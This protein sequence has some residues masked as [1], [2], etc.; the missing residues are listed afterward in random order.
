MAT[1]RAAPVADPAP[2]P[3]RN[4][5]AGLQLADEVVEFSYTHALAWPPES[6]SP[7]AELQAKHLLTRP[8][9]QSLTQ[10]LTTLRGQVAAER[11]MTDPRPDQ[12]PLHAGFIDLPTKLLDAHRRKGE[13][14]DLGRV[15]STGLRLREE[16]DRVVILG[17][18]AASLAPRALFEAL[19]ASHHNELPASARINRPRFYFE[20]DGLDSDALQELLA[21]LENN[22]VDP[23][24]RAERWGAVTIGRDADALETAVAFR[25]FRAEAARYYGSNSP[26]LKRVL[27]PVAPASGTM[28][29]LFKA[30]GYA[31]EDIV[32]LP[33]NLGRFA[34][35]SPAALLPAAVMGIDVRALLLGA[36]AMTRRF[37]EE[38][39]ERNPVLQL[40]AVNFLM[41]EELGK[42][43]R[44]LAVW[45]RKLE[46]LGRWYE[47]LLAGS[48]GKQGRG[49]TPLTAVMPRDLYNRGQLHQ[50]GPRDKVI[51]NVVVRAAKTQPLAIGM[52]DRNEDGLN[53]IAR[54]THAD[55]QAA[56]LQAANQALRDVARPTAD[57]TLP[58]LSEHVL[59]QVMQML[60][61]ATVVEGRLMGLNP[62][63]EP[64]LRPYKAHLKN[65]LGLA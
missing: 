38:P 46:A 55:L 44:V 41:T 49:P 37:L 25:L 40:A 15:I 20:G 3:T 56:S 22:C 35:L 50:D 13:A 12:Q 42:H 34:A 31:D 39:F 43:V 30:D 14:S 28:R 61:L 51:T 21:M 17:A 58:M 6:W 18:G 26:R 5:T 57:L 54:K 48:L 23:E 53:A 65:G 52:A 33:D 1:V 16:V 45:T 62:Y 59:G 19:L 7:L 8:R 29:E 10:Q 32:T 11:E 9:L 63:S 24:L 2:S 60:M 47:H 27:V 36:A 4:G 64:G